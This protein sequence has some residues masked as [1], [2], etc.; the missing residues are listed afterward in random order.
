[1]PMT[2]R[3]ELPDL[4]MSQSTLNN[5]LLKMLFQGI[6]IFKNTHTKKIYIYNSQRSFKC[7]EHTHMYF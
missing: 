7:P 2:K 6:S 5:T 4:K 1:M 3:H